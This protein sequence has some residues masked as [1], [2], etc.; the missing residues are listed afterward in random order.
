MVPTTT[1]TM[2]DRRSIGRWRR[3]HK[4]HLMIP[5]TAESAPGGRKTKVRPERVARPQFR[6]LADS[7]LPDWTAS[8]GCR[9]LL[10]AIE[11]VREF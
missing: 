4:A 1:A 11:E 5:A 7:V 3:P 10:T 8:S 6:Q 9:K 2:A